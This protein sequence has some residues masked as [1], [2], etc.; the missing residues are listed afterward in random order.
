MTTGT[1]ITQGGTLIAVPAVHYRASFAGE[2]NRLCRQPETRPDA[3]GV[4]LGPY[5]VVEIVNFMKKLGTG[6]DQFYR[7]PCMVGLMVRNRLIHPGFSPNAHFLQQHFKKPLNQIHPSLIRQRLH[8]SDNCI[9]GLSSTDS[10]I[11]AIRCAIELDIP[12][13]GV[14]LEEF[15]SIDST[16]MLIEDPSKPAFEFPGYVK[17]NERAADTVRD[18]YVDS[19]RELV[20]ASRLKAMMTRHKKV[21]FTCGLAHWTKIRELLQN[22]AL[23]AADLMQQGDVPAF[24]R[25]ILHPTIALAFVDNYPVNTTIYELSR[26]HPRLGGHKPW[27][28]EAAG[29]SARNILQHTYEEFISLAGKHPEDPVLRSEKQK[30]PDFERLLCAIRLVQPQHQL[31]LSNLL[32]VT[33][34]MMCPEFQRI[35]CQQI[36]KI[37]RSWA[38]LET[39][40]DLPM[41][42][43]APHENQGR[44]YSSGVDS[45]QIIQSTGNEKTAIHNQEPSAPFSVN[46]QH[47]EPIPF[48]YFRSWRWKYGPERRNP[49]TGCNS[50]VWP[51]CEA[52]L[53]G[54]AYKAARIVISETQ[55]PE[56]AAFEGSLYE[57][58]DIKATTRSIIRGEE[59]TFVRKSVAVKRRIVPDGKSPEPT[60]FIFDSGTDQSYWSLLM[61]GA[62]LGNHVKNNKR[63]QEVTSRYGS[64]FISSISMIHR[65]P[66]PEHLR[67]IVDS[68]SMIDGVTAFGSPCMHSLQG[69][70]WV[71][72][73][74][75][76]CCPVL[77]GA[78]LDLLIKDYRNRF[79]MTIDPE[80]WKHA[81]IR[82][83]IPYAK[84][85][86]IVVAPDDFRIPAQIYAEARKKRIGL[87]LLPLSYFSASGVSE[88]RKRIFV[89]SIDPDG[90]HFPPEVE[91]SLGQKADRYRELLPHYMQQQ[92]NRI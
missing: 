3:I 58:L 60:V 92:L 10:I 43:N 13:Y 40:P 63:Y 6:P 18:V 80:N 66:T 53:F 14:D 74:D 55:E 68:V 67:H 71:E 34:S 64:T 39:L 29:K 27:Y 30:F 38:S 73:N 85:R 5:K 37:S 23:R 48:S 21:L 79:Q 47:A 17:R 78:S 86:V 54:A 31:S 69:A 12:V 36:M 89:A 75:Y 57:G 45:Y 42:M 26:A 72:D 19:R 81:L 52:L 4:E 65:E 9:I 77:H 88:M 76:Q 32:E 61:G 1:I 28:A 41:L 20:M 16:G 22:N 62:S 8:F 51:P 11:E 56:S 33:F 44:N 2:V 24:T 46:Y 59:R 82:F 35:L 87:S 91:F 50:W 25:V 70:Q 90:L 84:E 83:A 15:A 7:L 49:S